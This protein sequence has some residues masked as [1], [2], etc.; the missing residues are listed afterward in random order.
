[1]RRRR[2]QRRYGRAPGGRAGFRLVLEPCPEKSAFDIFLQKI[3]ALCHLL[4]GRP[5]QIRPPFGSG[6]LVGVL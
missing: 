3:N 1:M 2:A 5:R 6:V 4:V